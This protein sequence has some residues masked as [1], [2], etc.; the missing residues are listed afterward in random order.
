MELVLYRLALTAQHL[1]TAAA[2]LNMHDV[3]LPG[4][5]GA[6]DLASQT[7]LKFLDPSDQ[8]VSWSAIR[9]EPT[10]AGVLAY[11]REVL[12][13]DFLDIVRSKR[14]K[15]T[16]YID[17]YVPKDSDEAASPEDVPLLDEATPELIAL[18]KERITCLLAKFR[19]SPE[20]HQVLELQCQTDGYSGLTNQEL[21]EQL[22]TSVRD[23]ENR[24]KRLKV[25]LKRL[26]ATAFNQEAQHA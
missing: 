18:Q 8:S 11:L 4:G 5:E 20:L 19:S 13:R 9:G 14:A 21:A 26:A 25:R 12:R 1:I 17:S 24:K 22:H 3:V 23:I 6:E 7:L 10:T 2:C 16:I 15:T